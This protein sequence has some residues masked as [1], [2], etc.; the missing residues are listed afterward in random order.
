M[1]ALKEIIMLTKCHS[2]L[3]TQHNILNLC[4]F[5]VMPEHRKNKPSTAISTSL[6]LITTGQVVCRS[7]SSKTIL[8]CIKIKVL[9]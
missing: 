8:N 1:N 7:F 6:N 3:V 2:Y 9:T 5:S 4:G